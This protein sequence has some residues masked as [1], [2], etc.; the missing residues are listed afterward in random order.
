MYRTDVP[1]SAGDV[2]R[3]T[4]NS[5]V[6]TYTKNGTAF[7][8]S[9]QTP[10]ASMIVAAALASLSATIVDAVASNGAVTGP[11]ITDSF[12]TSDG[13]QLGVQT[14]VTNVEI[15]WSLAFTPDGRLFFTE[16][17]G[18]VRAYANGQLLPAPALVVD[19]V[20]PVGEGGALGLAVH[21]QFAVNHFVYL[22]Y[23]A[24]TAS[25]SV[26]RLMRYRESNNT[27]IE[28]TLLLDG[29][30][31]F[32]HHDAGRLR[33]GPDGKL[34]VTTGDAADPNSSQNPSSLSG[35][36]LRLNDDGTIPPDNPFG[37]AVWT[38][39]HRD[40]QG[41]DWDPVTGLMWGSEHGDIGNDEINLLRA[42]HNYGWP[43]IEG[44]Q[45]QTGMDAPVAFFSPS[46]APSG[47]S[48]Y[49]GSL[50][51][52]LTGNLFVACLR[53]SEI[54]RVILNPQNR[55]QILATESWLL[56]HFGRIRDI[57]TGPDGALYFATNN[58]DGRGSP[59]ATDDRIFR[60]VP[61][62]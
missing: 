46:I 11:P 41:I 29:V 27:L 56:N 10:A 42:G 47:A 12:T 34:Y 62:Q 3:I 57:V 31:A 50:M 58:R 52:G 26:N 14:L 59:V 37:T 35:K 4:I 43:I 51:A 28:G 49:T 7:Y 5:G 20:Y 25:G 18:R 2:F 33:F 16:R 17:P 1:F 53:G 39:G 54:V 23:T 24:Q 55:T 38:L 44:A 6:V 36:I 40:P 13:L 15:P 32:D 60:I 45:T 22:F 48:F 9:A 30:A 8:V 21:P 61:L 19:D